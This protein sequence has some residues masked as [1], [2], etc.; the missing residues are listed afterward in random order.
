MSKK[1]D[2]SQ[3]PNELNKRIRFIRN[4][5]AYTQKEIAEF[6]NVDRA[7][8]AKYESG[9]RSIPIEAITGLAK[10]YSLSTDFILGVSASSEHIDYNS[11]N[12]KLS[13]EATAKLRMISNN[14]NSIYGL[15]TLL[16][17]RYAYKIFYFLGL[18]L[19]FPNN[20]YDLHMDSVVNALNVGELLA[21]KN[22]FNI[23][24]GMFG[25]EDD[26]LWVI[27]DVY[28]PDMFETFFHTYLTKFINDIRESPDTK[29]AFLDEIKRNYHKYAKEDIYRMEKYYRKLEAQ[30]FDNKK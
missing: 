4:K 22:D 15:N 5:N 8:Y 13:L 16:G 29:R 26:E 24:L 6:L 27:D 3:I 17:S 23:P 28:A 12:I 1:I 18:M 20:Y 11:L 30:D 25:I 10:I 19:R 14:D 7:T 21:Y 9:N 2:Y